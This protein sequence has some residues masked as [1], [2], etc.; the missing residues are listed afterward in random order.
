VKTRI[1]LPPKWLVGDLVM[2]RK[3]H[4]VEDVG[5]PTWNRSASFT[6]RTEVGEVMLVIGEEHNFVLSDLQKSGYRNVFCTVLRETSQV[7]VVDRGDV[8]LVSRAGPG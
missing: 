3:R 1:N 7:T 6:G 8:V 2:T 4:T 5:C